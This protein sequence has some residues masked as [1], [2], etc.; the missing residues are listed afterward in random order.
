MRSAGKRGIESVGVV[1]SG[2]VLTRL[3]RARRS[4]AEV[5]ALAELLDGR[6]VAVSLH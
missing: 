5:V 6:R 3:D 1:D 2:V 4:H